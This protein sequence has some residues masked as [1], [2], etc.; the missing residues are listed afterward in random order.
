M[1]NHPKHNESPIRPIRSTVEVALLLITLYSAIHTGNWTWF[2]I[3]AVFVSVAFGA[4]LWTWL[5]IRKTKKKALPGAGVD[6]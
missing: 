6:F 5:S 2:I 4:R 1:K 3:S